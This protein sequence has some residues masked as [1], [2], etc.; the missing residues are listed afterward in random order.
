M[1][2]PKAS[3]KRTP[4]ARLAL[5]ITLSTLGLPFWAGNAQA[6]GGHAEMVPLQAGLEEFGAT[7]KWDDYANLF[8]IAKDGVY[9]KVKP[10][11]KVAM[12]N[13][14]RIELTV[15]VVFKDHTAFMSKDFINQVFQSGLDKTFVV[16][17]RPN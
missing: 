11:S 16:E 9:L 4:L 17:T 5:A 3:P 8:T 7:V 12:L 1:F 10:D 6:H 2:S 13:G 14:K 15:P